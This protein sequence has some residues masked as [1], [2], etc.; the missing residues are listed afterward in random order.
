MTARRLPFVVLGAATLATPTLAQVPDL[1]NALDA[2]GR[3]MGMGGALYPTSSDTLTSFHNPAGLGFVDSRSIGAV[4]RNLPRSRTTTTVNGTQTQF[5]SSGQSGS[6]EL[7]HFGLNV[8]LGNGI[9]LGLS[10]T[11][12]GFLDDMRSGNQF[13]VGFGSVPVDEHATAK[14]E[15]FTL[16]LGQASRNRTFAWGAGVQFV[17]QHLSFSSTN[18]LNPV[19]G[20]S[21]TNHGIAGIFGVQ[22]FPSNNMELGLSYRTEVKLSKNN[23]TSGFLDKIPARLM[24]GI[25]IRK[26][27][28]RHGKDFLVFGADFAHFLRVSNGSTAFSRKAQTTGGFGLEYN[29][30]YS[31]ARIPIRFGYNLVQS[32]GTDFA[33][34]NAFTF[35]IGYRPGKGDWSVDLN[36][37][38]PQHGGTDVAIGFTYRL[39]K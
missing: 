39:P 3:S 9:G 28:F 31:G 13:V 33:S 14:S 34:R 36:F 27:G 10:Y 4:V 2:G 12:G 32:G 38:N 30:Q 23:S 21:G 7:T 35:G 18:P 25:A 24:G 5:S 26:D 8:P 22:I 29:Y 1:L 16:A 37:A 11:V 20:V 19:T 17:Q 6:K 15:F